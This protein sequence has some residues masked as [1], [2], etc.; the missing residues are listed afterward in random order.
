MTK[1]EAVAMF[2]GTQA[3]LAR[4]IGVTRSYVSQMPEQLRPE[5]ADRVVG[6]AVR[7]GKLAAVP[8]PGSPAIPVPN[9][10]A[11]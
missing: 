7:L 8:S 3:D 10:E 1:S 2:G 4:A 9:S 11:A 6:A 5:I